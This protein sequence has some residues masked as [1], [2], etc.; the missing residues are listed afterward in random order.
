M[1]MRSNGNSSKNRCCRKD[2]KRVSIT[3]KDVRD[4]AVDLV[5]PLLGFKF[6]G[7]FTLKIIAMIL[8]LASSYRIAVNQ[9][10]K[11]VKK[12]PPG[13]VIRYHL[14]KNVDIE[15]LENKVNVVLQRLACSILS[16]TRYEFAVDLVHIPYH[17]KHQK[18]ENEIVRSKAKHGTTHFHAYATLYVIV[19]GMRF[20][21]AVKYVQKG[22]PMDAVV[23]FMLDTIHCLGLRPKRLYLDKGFYAVPVIRLLKKRHI[24]AVIAAP[25]KGKKKGIKS[26]LR[27]RKSRIVSY[28]VRSGKDAEEIQLAI[29]CKYSKGKYNRKGAFYFAYVLLSVN[30]NPRTCYETYRKRFGI[31]SSYRMMNAVRARTSSRSPELRLLYIAISLILQNAW[32]YINWSY[33]REPKQGV[34]EAKEGLTL[35]SFMG[36]IIEGIKSYLG[37]VRTIFSVNRPKVDLLNPTI[38]C[39]YLESDTI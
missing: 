20:T 3:H 12:S 10:V 38:R 24:P 6:A 39:A 32:V 36:L 17:G 28:T 1:G 11:K 19:L 26:L 31:E 34:Q 29:V 21:L 25:A 15:Q 18:D 13:G 22:T 27:G 4:F 37:S 9:A 33:M 35:D 2:V 16:R 7:R 14:R 8:V 23:T 30:L 5:L